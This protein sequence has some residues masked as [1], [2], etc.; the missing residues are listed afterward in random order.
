MTV[1]GVFVVANLIPS[2][3]VGHLAAR[4]NRRRLDW[5]FYGI[6]FSWLLALV[7]LLI[8]GRWSDEDRKG[9]D[10][11]GKEMRDAY[12][13]SPSTESSEVGS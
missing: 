7:C 4:W 13:S 6:V 11:R 5:T 9:S 10:A 8:V 3:L 12:R 2:L 1:P